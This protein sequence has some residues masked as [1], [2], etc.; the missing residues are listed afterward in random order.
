M[1]KKTIPGPSLLAESEGVKENGMSG[2]TVTKT[3]VEKNNQIDI[4]KDDDE[5]KPK[6]KDFRILNAI[7]DS[8]AF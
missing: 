3:E 1:T 6:K 8:S 7:L 4:F 2:D 5:S